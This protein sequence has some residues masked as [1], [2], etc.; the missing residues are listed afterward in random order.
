MD[1]KPS[2]PNEWKGRMVW[3]R[4]LKREG[5]QNALCRYLNGARHGMGVS[6]VYYE[7]F[8]TAMLT[9]TRKGDAVRFRERGRGDLDLYTCNEVFWNVSGFVANPFFS[10]IDKYGKDEVPDL[11]RQ[12][13][14][15][16]SRKEGKIKVLGVLSNLCIFE[17]KLLE[18]LT[19]S[20]NDTDHSDRQGSG[21]KKKKNKRKR[22]SPTESSSLLDNDR[23]R[24]NVFKSCTAL[25]VPWIAEN[26]LSN[27]DGQVLK[28]AEDSLDELRRVEDDILELICAKT[29]NPNL[30]G[31]I[32]AKIKS[33]PEGA[34][35]TKFGPTKRLENDVPVCW[36]EKRSSSGA[37]ES[38]AIDRGIGSIPKDTHY[39]F[40]THQGIQISIY[41]GDI[42][43]E[44]VDV[45]VNAANSRLRH[46]GGVALALVRAGGY[47]IQQESD[48]FVSRNGEL[49]Q[50]TVCYTSG[51][52]LG[53]DHII[54]AVGPVW[55][56]R[57]QGRCI[58]QLEDSLRG[59]LYC[60]SS[61][62]ARSLATPI[63]SSGVYGV[64]LEVCARAFRVTLDE[65]SKNDGGS[66]SLKDI[67]IVNNDP[68]SVQ[69]FILDYTGEPSNGYQRDAGAMGMPYDGE[70]Q[71]VRRRS[72]HSKSA[73]STTST[74]KEYVSGLQNNDTAQHLMS[75]KLE[76]YTNTQMNDVKS[77]THADVHVSN[78]SNPSP[79]ERSFQP[80][81]TTFDTS[82]PTKSLRINHPTAKPAGACDLMT[83]TTSVAIDQPTRKLTPVYHPTTK[84]VTS[85]CPAASTASIA[86]Q[87]G[88]GDCPICV[89]D[90]VPLMSMTCCKNT[91]CNDCFDRHFDTDAKCPFCT[92]VVLMKKGNQ[93]S[94]TMDYRIDDYSSLPGY[95]GMGTII[96]TYHFPSGIQQEN[97]PNPGVQYSGTNRQAYL[98]ANKEGH[99]VLELLQRGFNQKVLFTIGKSV[100]TG[101][102]NCV[103]WNDVHH[104]TNTRGGSQSY[105]YPDPTY[106]S[107]VK[108]ELAAKGIK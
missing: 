25:V 1:S 10:S 42:T 16:Y 96:I 94:G 84:T 12:Y 59:A 58:R 81:T 72:R 41:C 83:K 21:K 99:E 47:I 61:I 68:S 78:F 100:T 26:Y 66:T 95:E 24:T 8:T 20:G 28:V 108:G 30:V 49:S 104:K 50:G 40:A 74:S 80:R 106:L 32:K 77:S 38:M 14:V 35:N 90:D 43:K 13:N 97:H 4:N 36:E 52:D 98:P 33:G 39:S 93:P 82:S 22:K 46:E 31:K 101:Q 3:L 63:I 107:R 87:S 7:D 2:L 29:P 15:S 62:G 9:F 71:H 88:R 17:R 54:H 19:K 67:R 57:N 91:I 56:D 65:F 11:A 69:K 70:E 37:K 89:D 86:S 64:P 105:G 103:L 85:P 23:L 76:Y 79:I 48:D 5:S 102:D 92:L 60:A 34:A 45:I 44:T 53:C 51:G 18:L 55:D 6:C 75:K 73:R 27:K